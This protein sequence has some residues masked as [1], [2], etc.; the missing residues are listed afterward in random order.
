M[1]AD[2]NIR[3]DKWLW[4]ARFFRTRALSKKAIDGG[5]IH[6]DGVR[7]KSSRSVNIDMLIKI[8]QGFSEKTVKVLAL[9]DQRGSATIAQALYQETAESIENREQLRLQNQSMPKS[10]HKPDK[11]QRRLIKQFI[12]K[13]S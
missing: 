2:K 10:E 11:K 9:S 5:K 7:G 6:C 4:A 3:L 1:M 12:R 13:Q 8:R